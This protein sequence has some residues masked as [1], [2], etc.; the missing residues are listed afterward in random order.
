M[1]N[2]CHHHRH[3]LRNNWLGPRAANA[4]SLHLRSQLQHFHTFHFPPKCLGHKIAPGLA[5]SI[6]VCISYI[7]TSYKFSS[8]HF[9]CSRTPPQAMPSHKYCF[10]PGHRMLHNLLPVSAPK[11]HCQILLPCKVVPK[12]ISV[13]T[14]A[15][16]QSQ[17][18]LTLAS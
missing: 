9:L 2:H 17:Q 11:E 16:L 14:N 5:W 15:E 8:V 6:C 12:Q 18:K 13:E 1:N 3:Q 7:V 10:G 4:I